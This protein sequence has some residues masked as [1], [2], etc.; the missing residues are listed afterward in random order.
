MLQARVLLSFA[1]LF[2]PTSVLAE[3]LTGRWSGTYACNSLSGAHFTL[4]TEQTGNGIISGTFFF[5]TGSGSSAHKGAYKVMGR[6]GTDGFRLQ[7]RDWIERPPGIEA[8]A[9][10]G[11][12]RDDGAVIEGEMEGCTLNDKFLGASA[13]KMAARLEDA[14]SEPVPP[15]MGGPSGLWKGEVTCRGPRKTTLSHPI[16]VVVLTDDNRAAADARVHLPAR[17]QGGAPIEQRTVLG[18][19]SVEGKLELTGL[20][21]F[22]SGGQRLPINSLS[23]AGDG[24]SLSGQI[25]MRGCDEVTLTHA[26]APDTPPLPD[27]MT[28]SWVGTAEQQNGAIAMRFELRN[29]TAG[30]FGEL[31]LSAPAHLPMEQRSKLH[32]VMMPVGKL[33][34]WQVMLPVGQRAFDISQAEVRR[35]T[36]GPV[37]PLAK[38]GAFLVSETTNGALEVVALIRQ[39]DFTNAASFTP[40]DP[41]RPNVRILAMQRAEA[42]LADAVASGETPPVI[43]PDT[44]GGTL[45][46][47]RSREAQCAVLHEWIRPYSEGKDMR[48]TVIGNLQRELA[49]AFTDANFEPVF[50]LPLAL[51]NDEERNVLARF[52]RENCEQGQGMADVGFAGAHVIGHQRGFREM[53]K[54]LT[55]VAELSRWADIAL[56]E[57]QAL[58][59][60][61]DSLGRIEQM[62]AGTKDRAAELSAQQINRLDDGLALRA[63]EIRTDILR[64]DIDGDLPALS[65]GSKENGA[66]D[67]LL[68]LAARIADEDI[69]PDARREL[70]DRI[71]PPALKISGDYV[72]AVI[73][74][75]PVLPVSLQGLAEARRMGAA[76]DPISDAMR[77][78]FGVDLGPRM[79]PLYL[80]RAMIENDPAVIDAFRQLLADVP[81]GRGVKGA[82][83][84]AA[85]QYVDE[86][87]MQRLPEYGAVY[88]AALEEAELRAITITDN[89]RDPS[90]DEPTARDIASFALE[91]VRA[92]NATISQM[93]DD[94]LQGTAAIGN[95]P[96]RALECLTLPAVLTGQKGFASELVSITKI[97]CSPDGGGFL[98]YFQQDIQFIGPG[99]APINLEDL[100]GTFGERAARQEVQDARFIPGKNGWQVIW[101]DMQ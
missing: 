91:R 60:T 83:R 4:E 82:V 100:V 57:A 99:G 87:T 62:K 25:N 24:L 95:N 32:L 96:V 80:R 59:S 19:E 5:E 40:G 58:S 20:G 71:A 35:H 39:G 72:T 26:G 1:L 53:V 38:A 15:T 74:E 56:D 12:T 88:K 18:G 47:A 90:R 92:V 3:P 85:L 11:R 34:G 30:G 36:L 48:R 69:L 13:E 86:A 37:G 101:G 2:T 65:G 66:L 9:L 79:E 52:I 76:L 67:Q 51:L 16:E 75:V 44:I 7:P 27:T 97:S 41:P 68:L 54:R 22:S 17:Q 14:N 8:L 43:F 10:N 23:L 50:G 78:R 77:A 28:G 89:S 21:N 49:E 94:C 33:N 29:G 73:A 61:A 46:A 45:V 6:G 81:S 55:D 42:G 63:R 98:C 93:E 31:R 84:D 64:A 70:H